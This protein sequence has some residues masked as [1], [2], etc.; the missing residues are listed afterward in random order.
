LDRKE[1]VVGTES[2]SDCF[3]V[4]SLQGWHGMITNC[5]GT[6]IQGQYIY[7]NLVVLPSVLFD[8]CTRFDRVVWFKGK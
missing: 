3:A 7:E 2:V 1:H 8:K 5:Q 6:S 4:A